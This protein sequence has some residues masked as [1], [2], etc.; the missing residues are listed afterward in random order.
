MSILDKFVKRAFVDPLKR[1]VNSVVQ[2]IEDRIDNSVTSAFNSIVRDLS[3]NSQN[4]LASR[5]G[6]AA[7][8]ELTDEFLGTSSS[9]INRATTEDICNSFIPKRL[10]T[11]SSVAGRITDRLSGA[12]IL[13]EGGSLLDGGTTMQ[14][15]ENIGKY[16]ISLKFRKYTR[17]NAFQRAKLEFKSSIAL[18]IPRNLVD[19]VSLDVQN[20]QST[21]M[22][23]VIMDSVLNINGENGLTKAVETQW[24]ALAF[25]YLS[26]KVEQLSSG[27]GSMIGAAMGVAPNPHMQTFFKGVNMREH[28]FEWTFAPRNP[29]ESITIQNIVLAIKQYSLPTFSKSGIAAL[30][31]PYLCMIDL[32]PWKAE[33]PL[34]K[35]KPALLKNVSIDYNPNGLPSF[36]AG[37][38]LPTSI[39]LRLEFVETEYFT[40]EDFG[41]APDEDGISKAIDLLADAANTSVSEVKSFISGALS[42]TVE[43]AASNAAA[44]TDAT[45]STSANQAAAAQTPKVNTPAATPKVISDNNILKNTMNSWVNIPKADT[46]FNASNGR[47]Y[48]IRKIDIR[49][50]PAG[51]TKWYEPGTY[52]VTVSGITTGYATPDLA[53]NAMKKASVFN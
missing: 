16:Y 12:N 31:Y 47:K 26:S 3:Q 9:E 41:R 15:P 38:T 35:F 21:G 29:D 53:Y 10:E 5:L 8:R 40:A 43:E 2:G 18:P 39:R 33:A 32:H 48:Y 24:G 42:G 30:Q 19:G 45:A 13:G 23:G 6:D 14:Y 37:T 49:T 17:P 11:S 50:N 52:L 20:N 4:D 27:A 44:N 46:T 51:S 28:S 1:G 36:F 22:S 25:S 7:K 34:I